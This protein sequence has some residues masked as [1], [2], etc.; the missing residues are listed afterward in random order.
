MGRASRRKRERKNQANPPQEPAWKYTERIVQR[1]EQSLAPD[2]KVLRDQ[3]LSSLI[4]G[5]LVQCDVT[6]LRN[7]G[8]R[9]T[10]SI[11]EVQDRG[12]KVEPNDYRGWRE[13]RDEV[14]ANSLICVS[15]EG[16]PQ[17]VIDHA[18][19][20]GDRV[21]LITLSDLNG[22]NWPLQIV[23]QEM[24][25]VEVG[26]ELVGLRPVESGTI[27]RPARTLQIERSAPIFQCGGQGQLLSAVALARKAAA[28]H[29]EFQALPVGVHPRR[30]TLTPPPGTAF[31]LL[32]EDEVVALKALVFDL[33]IHIKRHK[34]PLSCSGYVQYDHKGS[35][36]NALAYAMT[37][38]GNISDRH[39][40]ASMIFVAEPTGF[41]KFADYSVEG[42]PPDDVSLSIFTTSPWPDDPNDLKG[43]R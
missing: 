17:S 32:H 19:T 40:R 30:I 27:I 7:P 21:R 9:Q 29:P 25:F 41:L 1:L 42:L 6:I 3:K 20:Q 31:S 8:P 13:K 37:A 43:G 35:F 10:L 34:L 4:T 22:G 26:S 24:R 16:F 11:V 39:V 38:E 2:A 18:K 33:R 28:L 12:R 15:E 14:G 36:G 5:H 23:G